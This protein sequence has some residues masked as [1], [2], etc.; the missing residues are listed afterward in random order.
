MDDIVINVKKLSKRYRI[1]LKDEMHDSFLGAAID[2][3]KS[4]LKNYKKYRSLYTFDDKK[5]DNNFERD[6]VSDDVIWALKDISFKVKR[7]EVLGI[8]GSNGAGK[9]TLLKIL[10]KITSPSRG[11]VDIRGNI[12]SLLEV[13]TGFHP[14]LTGRE[15][16]YLNGTILGMRKL[17]LWPQPV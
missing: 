14:E 3:V 8:I 9:T 15:N 17:R 2:F 6:T 10:S 4:P 13:G 5:I 7:G 11:R 16:I 12:S 1:G